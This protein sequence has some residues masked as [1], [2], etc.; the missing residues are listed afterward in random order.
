MPSV[1]YSKTLIVCPVY[2]LY[3]RFFFSFSLVA[4][5]E[6][7]SFL[8]SSISKTSNSLINKIRRE[9]DAESFEME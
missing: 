9:V 6:F 3:K 4:K 2:A 1:S 5:V 8:Y 7:D